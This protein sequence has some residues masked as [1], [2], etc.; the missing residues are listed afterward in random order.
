MS[1]LNVQFKTVIVNTSLGDTKEISFQCTQDVTGEVI[2]GKLYEIGGDEVKTVTDGSVLG[3]GK[4]DNLTLTIDVS[5][6]DDGSYGLKIY[7]A[8]TGVIA[9][10]IV[11]VK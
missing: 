8:E 7:T 3:V 9:K 11:V 4:Q 5:G 6:V 10:S 1:Q 2:I